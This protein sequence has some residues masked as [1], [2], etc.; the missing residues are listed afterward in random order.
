MNYRIRRGFIFCVLHL[1]DLIPS[2]IKQLWRE[3]CGSPDSGLRLEALVCHSTMAGIYFPSTA[4]RF[5]IDRLGYR[6]ET[7]G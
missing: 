6:Y 3:L 2:L 4:D 1:A 5:M 7:G